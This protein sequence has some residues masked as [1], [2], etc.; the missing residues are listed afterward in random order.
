MHGYDQ[1][2]FHPEGPLLTLVF[3]AGGIAGIIGNP[4]GTLTVLS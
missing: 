2:R 4:G 1:S 3:V